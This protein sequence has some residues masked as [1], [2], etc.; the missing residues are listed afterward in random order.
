MKE[1]LKV[2]L[3]L[4]ELKATLASK[5]KQAQGERGE[6]QALMVSQALAVNQGV[7]A[8]MVHLALQGAKEIR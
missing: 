7:L 5:V 1:A 2:L 3:D 6:I 8:L 4:L